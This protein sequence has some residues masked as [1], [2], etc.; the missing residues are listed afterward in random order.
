MEKTLKSN[1]KLKSEED[2]T[3][4]NGIKDLVLWW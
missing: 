3:V 4:K 1:M 2:G